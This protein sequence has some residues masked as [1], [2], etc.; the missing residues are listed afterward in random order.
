VKYI[1]ALAVMCLLLF[2]A[3]RIVRDLPFDP[4]NNGGD[5]AATASFKSSTDT[6]YASYPCTLLCVDKGKNSYRN[7]KVQTDLPILTKDSRKETD[8][9]GRGVIRFGT[10]GKCNVIVYGVRQNRVVDSIMT[11]PLVVVNPFVIEVDLPTAGT[12]G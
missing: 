1:W 12:F 11:L 10:I 2:C 8:E 7:F 5:Y 3:D 9:H 6:L 4:D